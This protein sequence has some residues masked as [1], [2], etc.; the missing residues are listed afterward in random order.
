VF[1][2]FRYVTSQEV[3]GVEVH[4]PAAGYMLTSFN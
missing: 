2:G 4:H 1:H 3:A